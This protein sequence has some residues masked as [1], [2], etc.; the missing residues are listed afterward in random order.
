MFY[1]ITSSALSPSVPNMDFIG[2]TKVGGDYVYKINVTSIGDATREASGIDDY[3][4][5]R[6][7]PELVEVSSTPPIPSALSAY[8]FGIK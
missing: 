1:L 4:V 5:T 2:T 8:H 7:C 6:T 3:K